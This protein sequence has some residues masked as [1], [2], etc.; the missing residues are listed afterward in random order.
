MAQHMWTFLK[1]DTR[2][3]KITHVQYSTNGNAM[4]YSLNS[5]PLVI[6]EAWSFLILQRICTIFC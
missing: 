5:E 6:D 3:G 2:N 1:L 4:E